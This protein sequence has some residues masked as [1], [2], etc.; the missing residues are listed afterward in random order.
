VSSKGETQR[1]LFVPRE[2]YDS[3]WQRTFGRHRSDAP[4]PLDAAT[5][6]SIARAR[7]KRGTDTVVGMFK[8]LYPPPPPFG[9]F[10][11]AAHMALEGTPMVF[12]PMD[13]LR[14]VGRYTV[15]RKHETVHA[16]T[17]EPS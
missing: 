4:A 2:Q 6:K 15:D 17:W 8:H 9:P 10:D 3:A 11:V 14:L 13:G 12:A 1:S 16:E 5:R 7:R